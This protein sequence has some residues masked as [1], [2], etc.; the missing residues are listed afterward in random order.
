MP[1]SSANEKT[2]T[3]LMK[4]VEIIWQRNPTEIYIKPGRKE[5]VHYADM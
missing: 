4:N 5:K 1:N 3:N 2:S